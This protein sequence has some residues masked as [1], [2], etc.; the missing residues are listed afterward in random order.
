MENG[1]LFTDGSELT[2]RNREFLGQILPREIIRLIHKNRK[3]HDVIFPLHILLYILLYTLPHETSHL[4]FTLA[5][6]FFPPV[7]CL[8]S[9]I[10]GIY[11]PRRFCFSIIFLCGL[12]NPFWLIL[13][14]ITHLI[15]RRLVSTTKF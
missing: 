6:R 2:S 9:L 15:R 10:S 13:L 1:K 4:S 11:P 14:I 3:I 8:I 5:K 7:P 12:L